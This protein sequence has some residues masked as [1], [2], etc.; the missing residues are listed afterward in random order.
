MFLGAQ[1][2]PA[3]VVNELKQGIS[4]GAIGLLGNNDGS[5]FFANFSYR[6]DVPLSFDPPARDDPPPGVL[7]DWEISRAY[8]LSE[9]DPERRPEEQG[10]TDLQWEA[11]TGEPGGLVD[12]ARWRG[13]GGYQQRDPSCQTSPRQPAQRL[14]A[15]TSSHV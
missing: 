5:S 1:E 13:R 2:Q 6:T 9:L 11:V 4:R 7:T 10:L 15:I 12:I 3:L 8:P 14:P